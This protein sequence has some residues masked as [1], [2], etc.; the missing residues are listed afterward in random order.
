MWLVDIQYGNWIECELHIILG[1]LSSLHCSVCELRLTTLFWLVVILFRWAIRNIILIDVRAVNFM[2]RT[3]VTKQP[4]QFTDGNCSFT[5]YNY[6]D[7][8]NICNYTGLG[9]LIQVRGISYDNQII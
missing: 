8:R 7:F 6:V 9:L 5:K 4:F 2:K 1:Q 3:R